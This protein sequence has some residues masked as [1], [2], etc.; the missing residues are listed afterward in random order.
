M[1]QLLLL[2]CIISLSGKLHAQYNDQPPFT[3]AKE[4][5]E[6]YKKHQQLEKQ[7][8]VNAIEFKSIGPTVFSGRVADIDVWEEDP[9]HF[10]VAYA[11]GGVWKTTNNGT[12]FEPLFD[13]EMVMTIGDI[14]VDCKSKTIWVGTGEV[15]S[16]RSSYFSHI[17]IISSKI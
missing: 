10:Y 1:R 7:S 9:S 17:S 2:F 13:D 5:I 11:S 4:R 6:S 3:P 16:S 15:N 8:Y 14:A 12:S